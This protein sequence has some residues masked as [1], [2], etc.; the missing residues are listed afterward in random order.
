VAPQ[1]LSGMEK[2][3]PFRMVLIIED[4]YLVALMVEDAVI[5]AGFDF[6]GLAA[7]R[8]DAFDLFGETDVALVGV[9]L[10]K[11]KTGPAIGAEL[12]VAGKTV[13]FMTGN[14][15]D[16]ASGVPGALGVISKPVLD[17]ELAELASY[18]AAHCGGIK[19][20]ATLP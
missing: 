4:Q 20:P 13:I 10:G 16:V 19:H 8:Q 2:L 17:A 18:A 14:L 11:G 5:A 9:D 6:Y 12:A 1:L 15:E 7:C 3:N